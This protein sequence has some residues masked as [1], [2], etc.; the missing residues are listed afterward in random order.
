MTADNRRSGRRGPA[1]QYGR[2]LISCSDGTIEL[3]TRMRCLRPFSVTASVL[4]GSEPQQ[5][6]HAVEHVSQR[7]RREMAGR[8]SAPYS[9]VHTLKV[10][11]KDHAADA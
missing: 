3:S 1:S 2:P 11:C 6:G 5:G 10:V 9:P 7:V 8:F 4:S